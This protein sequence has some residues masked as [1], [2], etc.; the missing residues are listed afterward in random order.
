MFAC[1]HHFAKLTNCACQKL[2]QS[3]IHSP[4]NLHWQQ[5]G[6]H[7]PNCVEGGCVDIFRRMTVQAKQDCG[8]RL[9]GQSANHCSCKDESSG[10]NPLARRQAL[11]HAG[12]QQPTFH[13]KIRSQI[14]SFV[15]PDA[16][17]FG[18]NNTFSTSETL[19]QP[20]LMTRKSLSID[21]QC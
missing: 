1:F 14:E 10:V 5:I 13:C 7:S 2:P 17:F 16:A 6:S 3:P 12:N 20:R 18:A 9:A 4:K 15:G 11:W 21:V 8:G 19:E